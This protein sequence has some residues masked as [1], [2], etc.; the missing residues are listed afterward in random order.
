M[1]ISTKQNLL[2]DKAKE[3]NPVEKDMKRLQDMFKKNQERLIELQKKYEHEEA[4]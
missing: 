3:I 4:E 1:T 2:Q